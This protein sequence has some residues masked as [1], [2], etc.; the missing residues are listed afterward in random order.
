M[1]FVVL[2][3]NC[4]SLPSIANGQVTSS[5]G[6]LYPSTATYVCDDGYQ[7]SGS[8]TRTCDEYGAWS[9]SA[10]V[11]EGIVC[12]PLSLGN[13]T[14]S[15]SGSQYPLTAT[16]SCNSGYSLVGASSVDCRPDGYWTGSVPECQAIS[17]AS[18]GSVTHGSVVATNG[19]SYPSTATYSCEDG[20]ELSGGQ[21]TRVCSPTDGSWSDS[22]PS[23][24]GVTCASLVGSLTNGQVSTSNG[25]LYPST[26]TYTCSSGYEL[27][28]DITRSC[29]TNGAWAGSAPVCQGERFVSFRFFSFSLCCA[30]ARVCVCVCV[31]VSAVGI[32]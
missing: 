14:V 17:C 15:M 12:Q 30:R 29:Q 1:M 28:G 9:G 27:I 8:L 26:A 19:G 13:G 4:A 7:L 3:I 32:S 6:N 20:Y 10:P 16:F 21:S 5:N 31:C 23:C 11:C 24:V 18:L 22:A 2:G 25:G